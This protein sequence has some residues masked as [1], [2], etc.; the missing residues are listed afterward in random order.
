MY[1]ILFSKSSR[2]IYHLDPSNDQ[3][4]LTIEITTGDGTHVNMIRYL[5]RFDHQHPHSEI[6]F[7]HSFMTLGWNLYEF[8]PSS[9]LGNCKLAIVK[10]VKVKTLN[11]ISHNESQVLD[12]LWKSDMFTEDATIDPTAIPRFYG[13]KNCEGEDVIEFVIKVLYLKKFK[14]FA[15]NFIYS[16]YI[17]YFKLHRSL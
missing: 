11:S 10:V 12:T 9:I 16:L 3:V 6:S 1:I 8:W 5:E 7:K 17:L 13:N 2:E 15:F 4:K 14:T